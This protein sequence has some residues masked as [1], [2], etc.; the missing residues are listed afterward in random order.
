MLT[1]T[2]IFGA[3]WSDRFDPPEPFQMEVF[4]HGPPRWS[5]VVVSPDHEFYGRRL[6]LSQ[7]HKDWN[8]LVNVTIDASET[9]PQINGH[10]KL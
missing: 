5:G 9:V 10:A 3:R 2:P 1:V 8:G 4:L 6:S 7:R